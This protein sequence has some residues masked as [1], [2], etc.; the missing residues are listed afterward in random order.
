[1]TDS[2]LALPT[3]QTWPMRGGGLNHLAAWPD[4]VPHL[5]LISW[6]QSLS[7][8]NCNMDAILLAYL[9][10]LRGLELRLNDELRLNK[11]D[12][13]SLEEEKCD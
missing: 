2:C 11:L 12:I 4:P 8:T 3:S 5:L 13:F 6:L 9:T 10:R 7:Q 1:M